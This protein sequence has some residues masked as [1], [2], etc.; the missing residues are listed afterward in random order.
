MRFDKLD[1]RNGK[2]TTAVIESPRGSPYKY[3][4]DPKNKVFCLSSALPAGSVFPFDFGFVP[5]TVAG[6]GDP[7]D[8]LVLMDLP[9]FTGCVLAVR[10][11]GVIEAEQGKGKKKVR[12]DRLIAVAAI[13]HTHRDTRD[14]KDVGQPTVDEIKR[15]FVNYNEQKGEPFK[16]L[17]L[18]GAR[19]ARS[20]L[21]KA[22]RKFTKKQERT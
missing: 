21:K 19:R 16:I 12:N 2:G 15:F 20:L 3:N 5:S 4:Y 13:S 6:D 11:I 1:P 9:S 7:I 17:G 14:L 8:V 22:H 10:P 18:H